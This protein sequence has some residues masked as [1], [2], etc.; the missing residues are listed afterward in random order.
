MAVEEFST[1]AQTISEVMFDVYQKRDID[2]LRDKVIE[3]VNQLRTSVK[4]AAAYPQNNQ[5]VNETNK[6]RD[7]LESTVDQMYTVLANTGTNR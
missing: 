4:M 7:S 3:G 1:I 2:K 5:Y 6:A